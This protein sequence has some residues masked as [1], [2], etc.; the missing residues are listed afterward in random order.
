MSGRTT[1]TESA[2]RSAVAKAW[3]NERAL[4]QQGKGTRNWTK[5]QQAQILSTGRCKG[6]F[7]HHKLSVKNN[8]DQAGNVD[9]IQFLNKKEHIEAHDKNFKNDPKGR[10][11]PKTGKIEKYADQKVRPEPVIDLTQ[12]M[13]DSRKNS[14]IRK[15]DN[16]IAQKRAQ[17]KALR[18]RAVNKTVKN[19]ASRN[20]RGNKAETSN[21]TTKTSQALKARNRQA[22]KVSPDG[23]KTS[24]ALAARNRQTAKISSEGTK[25]SQALAA[26][27]TGVKGGLGNT[28]VKGGLG[29]VGGKGGHGNTGGKGAQG[30][31]GGKGGTAGSTGGAGGRGGHG[32]SGGHG[33]R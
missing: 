15:Y 17:A 20:R 19:D 7:G 10:Y 26:G 11:D 25:T 9:N 32:N 33:S 8:P 23:T 16:M 24:R 29:N 28:G 21:R 5:S 14:A 18:Q 13:A 30:N 6:F 12:K 2:R 1:S 22:A 31:A 3:A 4:I 27:R